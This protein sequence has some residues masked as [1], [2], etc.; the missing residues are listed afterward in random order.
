M[1]SKNHLTSEVKHKFQQDEAQVK[2]TRQ[3]RGMPRHP[4]W[5]GKLAGV[6]SD[7]SGATDRVT[8]GYKVQACWVGGT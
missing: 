5:V 1:L 4:G 8:S 3:D 6:A 7:R 2:A